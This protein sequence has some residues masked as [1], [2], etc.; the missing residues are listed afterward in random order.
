MPDPIK[1]LIGGEEVTLPLILNFAL[2]DRAYPSIEAMTEAPNMIARTAAEVAFVSCVVMDVKP[3]LTVPEIK[4]RLRV[5][6]ED[7]TDEREALSVAVDQVIR[8]SGLFRRKVAEPGEAV[9]EEVPVAPSPAA[10]A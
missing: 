8:Q 5:N 4:R 7:G 2:L 3:E 10:E 1:I 6:V 9:P